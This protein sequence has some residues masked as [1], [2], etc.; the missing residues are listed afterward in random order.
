[1][2]TATV[3]KDESNGKNQ[4]ANFEESACLHI[5]N[6]WPRNKEVH[7]QTVMTTEMTETRLQM[8]LNET[9]MVLIFTWN[10]NDVE[11]SKKIWAH[12]LFWEDDT[13]GQWCTTDP[14][15]NN[16]VGTTTD[17]EYH[18]YRMSDPTSIVGVP[19]S[20]FFPIWVFQS[21]STWKKT[22]YTSCEFFFC[23]V[24]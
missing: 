9:C 12:F 16:I 5:D 7:T 20:I 14:L 4:K 8:S 18:I 13:S 11:A 2:T 1:M 24:C 19:D 3:L 15:D 23:M 10:R 6:I 22:L 17:R 21:N